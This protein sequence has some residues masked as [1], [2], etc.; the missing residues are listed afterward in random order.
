MITKM[1]LTSDQQRVKTLLT[2]TLTLLCKNGLNFK[3]ELSIEALIG[4]TVDQEDVFL[5]SIKEIVH[6]CAAT[7]NAN[8]ISLPLLS[9]RRRDLHVDVED[10]STV[11]RIDVDADLSPAF[12]LASSSNVRSKHIKQKRSSSPS[13][14]ESTTGMNEGQME[15]INTKQCKTSSEA[16]WHEGS[17]ILRSSSQPV[18]VIEIDNSLG[19]NG[20]LVGD[21][22]NGSCTS[23]LQ[24]APLIKEESLSFELD[25]LQQTCT[26][27]YDQYLTNLPQADSVR[28]YHSRQN[29]IPGCSGWQVGSGDQQTFGQLNQHQQVGHFICHIYNHA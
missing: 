3:S 28:N 22:N 11:E 1:V 24:G 16:N 25:N 26:P 5:I 23:V 9:S 8:S 6:S 2:E 10:E 20:S 18:S 27:I 15:S 12:A 13:E 17:Q 7:P 29:A 19:D 21:L 14:E 4:V